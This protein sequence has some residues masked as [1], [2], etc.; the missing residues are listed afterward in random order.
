MPMST[1]EVL[2]CSKAF[3]S[4]AISALAEMVCAISFAVPAGRMARTGS[5]FGEDALACMMP[6]STSLT[7]PSPP[8]AISVGLPFS[9]A[10]LASSIEWP[11]CSEMKRSTGRESVDISLDS[12][13]AF[14]EA[15]LT[16]AVI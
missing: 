2:F 4:S 6:L 12:D 15:P 5:M 16:I 11:G 8:T 13:S 9:A 10:F 14:L 7:V 1:L 3:S